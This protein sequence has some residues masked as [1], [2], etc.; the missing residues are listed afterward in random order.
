LSDVAFSPLAR[1]Y[2]RNK[3]DADDPNRL[4]IG[5]GDSLVRRTRLDQGRCGIQQ[6]CDPD[7]G[8]ADREASGKDD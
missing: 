5:R 6:A 4:Q 2:I 1:M 7:G 3:W 8:E